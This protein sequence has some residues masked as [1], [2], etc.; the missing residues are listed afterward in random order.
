MASLISDADAVKSAVSNI[1]TCSAATIVTLKGL[2][3]PKDDTTS[4]SSSVPASTRQTKTGRPTKQATTGAARAPKKAKA[5]GDG[6]KE[7]LTA[8]DRAALA[9]QVLNSALKALGDAAKPVTQTPA[10]KQDDG[11]LVKSATRNA[12][13]RSNSMPMSPLQPRSL[14]RVSTSPIKTA[15]SMSTSNT[16]SIN[17]LSTVECARVAFFAL[18][19]LHSSGKI[20]LP[21]LQLEAGM[22][23]FVGK[24]ISLG[25]HDQAVKEL[26]ILKRRLDGSASV[27]NSKTTSD[28]NKNSTNALAELL[29]FSKAKASG[30]A[31]S[32]IVTTQIQVLRILA[33]MRKPTLITA[34]LPVLRVSH[35]SSVISFLMS[36]AKQTNADRSKLA[37][38]ME[39]VSQTLLSLS[40]SVSSSQDGIAS[41]PRFS[42]APE[43]A[44]EI[45]GL[46]LE[47]RLLWWRLAGHQGDVDKDILTPLSRCV[48]ACIRR[49]KG[50]PSVYR[51]CVNT[52]NGVYELI[53]ALS[54]PTSTSSKSSQS[55]IYQM[56]ATL[57]RESGDLTD[58]VQWASKLRDSAA[59]ETETAAKFCSIAA[60][61]L[62][63]QLKLDPV[64]YLQ[65]GALLD[66]VLAGVQ[67]SLRG[68]TTELDELLGNVSALRRASI[69]ILLGHVKDAKGAPVH[70]PPST[71]ELLETLVLQ[72]PRFCLRWLGKPPSPTSSTKD[73]LR[74][75]QRRQLLLQS[76]HHTLD[77]AFILAKALL[78]EQRLSWDVLETMLGD[79]LMLLE[80]MGE[81]PMPDEATSYYVKISHFYYMKYDHLRQRQSGIPLN[82]AALKALRRSIDCVKNRSAKEREKAQLIIKFERMAELC[83][84]L[85]LG[86]EALEALK[87]IRNC[88]VD[89]GVLGAVATALERHHPQVA[90]SL[91]YEADVLYRTLTSIARIETD[92]TDWTV[93][94]SEAEQAAAHEHRLQFVLL[95][96]EKRSQVTLADPTVDALLRIYI[97]TRFPVRRLRTLLRLLSAAVGDNELLS[98]IRSIA[99]DAVQLGENDLGEDVP[100]AKYLPHLKALFAS[101]TGLV[102]GY[103][104]TQLLENTLS[105]WRSMI[106]SQPTKEGLEG[107]IDGVTDLLTHLSSVA[108]FLRLKGEQSLLDIVVRLSADISRIVQGPQPEQFV[109]SQTALALHLMDAGLSVQAAEIFETAE[110]FVARS[111]D[112]PGYLATELQLAHA[113]FSI[114]SGST[115][116]ANDHLAK[117]AISFASN[118]STHKIP[119]SRRKLLF[120]YASYLRGVAAL[121]LGSSHHALAYCRDSVRVLFAE[122]TRLESQLTG[123]KDKKATAADDSTTA[124]DLSAAE[125]TNTAAPVITGPD[126]WMYFRHLFRA[127]LQLSSIY[128]HLGMYQQ[129]TY[130]AESAEKMARATNSRF[131]IAQATTW[132]ASVYLKASKPEKSAELVGHARTA[133]QA[134]YQS[135]SSLSLL[136][137]MA[138]VYRGLRDFTAETEMVEMAE[139]ILSKLNPKTIA[140]EAA[141]QVSETAD[142]ETKMAKLDIKEKPAVRTTRR[143]VRQPPVKK[144]A[145]R[146][147]V[148]K[149]KAATLPPTP[150]L[151]TGDPYVATLRAGVLVQKAMSLLSQKNWTVAASLLREAVSLPKQSS[152][153]GSRH[154]VM[155][156]CLLGQ[157]LESMAR[158]SV[159]SVVHD[160][161]LSFPTLAGATHDRDRLSLTKHSPPRKGRSTAT[162]HKKEAS[163]DS[164]PAGFSLSLLEAQELLLEAHAEVALTGDGSLLHRIS[165]MLQTVTLVL[166]TISAKSKAVNHIG[167]AASSA[168][169]ARN[170]TWRRER[171]VVYQ[172]K[173]ANKFD[174]N[175]WPAA[176]CSPEDSRRTSLGPSTDLHK[177]QRDYIDI[178]PKTWTAISI[179]LSENKHDLCITRLQAGQ[180]PFVIRLPLERASSRDADTE[181]FNFQQGRAEL[182]EIIKLANETCHDARDMS[183]KGAKAAWWADR[184]ALDNRM[185]ELLENIERD[186]LG[187]FRGIFS[188]HQRR[189]DLLARFQKSF[190]NVLDKHLPSRRQVRGKKTRG[191][192]AATAPTTA[193]KITLDPRIL[194]LFIG[195]GDA[196]KDDCDFDDA[197]TDLLYFVVD[198]LQF[199]G[200]RN[201]YDEVDF[202]AMV[203]ETFDALHAYHAAA[204]SVDTAIGAGHHTILVLDKA[205]HTFPWES[206]PCTQGNAVSRVP[207]LACLRR[208]ILEARA[209]ASSNPV[210]DTH[211]KAPAGHHIPLTSGTYIVNPSNDLP[212]TLSTFAVPLKSHLPP[213]WTSIVSRPPTEPEFSTALTS[214]PLFLYFGHGSG[215]QYI[216][217]NTIRRLDPG[218][219]ATA[220]LWGCSSAS[221]ADCGE[222]EV[223]GPA[224]NYLMAG[225]P[226]VTGTLW[227]VTDRDIDRFAART[228]EGW[229][230]VP[231]GAIV[232]D[233]GKKK[234]MV[235]GGK[236]AGGGGGSSKVRD[237]SGGTTR[238]G[239]GK[240]HAAAG[241]GPLS[242]VEAVTCAREGA[243]R[244]RYL[245]AAA[246]VVYG[247][248]VY[249]DK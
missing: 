240:S 152:G 43:T 205:L 146:T 114:T 212:S 109:Q 60:Q 140:N 13:R 2:L 180:T 20:S 150:N 228:L 27:E 1:S 45:Q 138:T 134:D 103:P 185:K 232:V 108:D 219:R 151:A 64:K 237:T 72:C 178:I 97:P 217:G 88:L 192:A 80:Y 144:P 125:G 115:A 143:T 24:L 132:M 11:G 53:P 38:Q 65:E 165:A 69:A 137:Q 76:I 161:T 32:L 22:S 87:G 119:R 182:L 210:T 190:Q 218:C 78:G 10:K 123:T 203:V 199:H 100:L 196:T 194:E 40:P 91:N 141:T 75:E 106:D 74:Y 16:T 105:V 66:E 70:P 197:L 83:K 149:S 44:L 163:K 36:M 7:E 122:W 216:R 62:A 200:E 73:Y 181:V 241:V 230:V 211:P 233:D 172:E 120:A 169:L 37:R 227:D 111:E 135:C 156:A 9:T 145:S 202:D 159:F 95:S 204:K 214:S 235:G 231:A 94:F 26:R 29:D 42:I 15:R 31:M 247:I 242:L 104:D 113:D 244:F 193:T 49:L 209:P 54:K 133:L 248:P 117:A 39:T 222:F 101:C 170:L 89:D 129:T 213:S 164:V 171:K 56:L 160:S 96:S 58:A 234:K 59:S 136:C 110:A 245:T 221:L 166:S 215:A 121:E 118:Q 21:E 77:S 186:W 130:Y 82:S 191:A 61:L 236:G 99:A 246:V 63:F 51:L 5:T 55:T 187:G 208:M 198:I 57:A 131:H 229:G 162:A 148:A 127:L 4:S 102:D 86:E 12:L 224:W 201:A 28:D 71:K 25:L 67:G 50:R 153:L 147:T 19:S 128:A 18:R 238:G 167:H 52:V 239:E 154:V 3:L 168:D 183:I 184:E 17:C 173:H 34:A 220:L 139:G 84:S 158:D 195:L 112:S 8:R 243:C 223:H 98:N 14:N 124:I 116:K 23:S 207:S 188:Q 107:S 68:E 90:W 47:S 157:S 81:L 79:S 48:A 30:P 206:L 225:C 126:F 177:F 176:L 6:N 93:D 174:G 189:P 249:I 226:A 142:L 92:W 179:S 175:E 85:G 46:G 33:A 41:D 155:A 35:S